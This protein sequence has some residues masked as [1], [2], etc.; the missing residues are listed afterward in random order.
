MD[1]MNKNAANGARLLD[2]LQKVD[3]C[4]VE[5]NLYLDAYPSCAEA[6]AFYR[7]LKE[8]RQQLAKQYEATVGPL[9]ATAS[10]NAVSWDWI[11]TP[12]PWE[13]VANMG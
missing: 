9:T 3:F 7:T 12:W 8:K 5:T 10:E 1:M 13:L 4:L 2:E 6:L 11:K